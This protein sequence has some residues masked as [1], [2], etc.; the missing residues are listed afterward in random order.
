MQFCR[1]CCLR[2]A[3]TCALCSTVLINRAPLNV[4]SREPAEIFR[5][6]SMAFAAPCMN[7]VIGLTT[8]QKTRQRSKAQRRPPSTNRDFYP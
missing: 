2:V 7:V 6:R 1:V 5:A 4:R 8:D 3:D